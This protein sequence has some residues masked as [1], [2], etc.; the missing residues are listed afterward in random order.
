MTA[1]HGGALASA[2]ACRWAWSLCGAPHR[3]HPG[4]HGLCLQRRAQGNRQHARLCGLMP[5]TL[6]AGMA[7]SE[8]DFRP[9]VFMGAHP[10]F[11][12]HDPGRRL[13]QL[14]AQ[15]GGVKHLRGAAA[16]A[17]E[18]AGMVRAVVV[19]MTMIVIVI[20]IVRALVGAGVRR[21]GGRGRC[22][23]RLPIGLQQSQG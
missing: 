4:G 14:F 7:A 19:S 18:Q 15:P 9:T 8:L 22:R 1:P 6:N 11:E 5:G 3:I 20:V 13:L 12:A 16:V 23:C 21:R 10:A 17:G 2:W